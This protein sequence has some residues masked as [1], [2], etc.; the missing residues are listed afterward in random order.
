MIYITI[1]QGA[2]TWHVSEYTHTHDGVLYDGR[3]LNAVKIVSQL[4]EAGTSGA[5]IDLHIKNPDR[6]VSGNLWAAIVEVELP[7]GIVWHGEVKAY[8]HDGE[9]VLYVSVSDSGLP[10]LDLMIPDEVAHVFDVSDLHSSFVDFTVPIALGGTTANPLF[11]KGILISKASFV[12]LLSVGEI[13][14]VIKVYKGTE[15]ITSGFTAYTGTSGQAQYPGF[16]CIVFNSDP[17]NDDGTWPDI[18]ADVVGVKLGTC[19][20]AECRN[21]ARILYYLLTTARTGIG[22][23]GLGVDA[24]KIDTASF[25]QAIADCDTFG[26]H[27]DGVIH[28]KQQARYWVDQITRACRGNY[29]T[30]NGKRY[31]SIGKT[32]S[33]VQTYD[34]SN[35]RLERHGK[36]NSSKRR[37]RVVIDYRYNPI[38]QCF[39][40]NETREDSASISLIKEQKFS[41]QLDLVSEQATAGAIA[42]FELNRSK[43]GE[44]RIYF[45]TLTPAQPGQVI[46]INRPDLGLNNALFCVTSLDTGPDEYLI[47]AQSYSDSIHTISTPGAA[48]SDV[49]GDLPVTSAYP[50]AA[51]SGLDVHSDV[52]ILPDGSAISY[53]YGSYT[54]PAG[55]YLGA[56]VQWG[57]G[58]NPSTWTALG[59]IKG[60]TFRLSPV[61]GGTTYTIKVT[62]INS[63]GSSPSITS[64]ITAAGDTV[65]PGIP[66]I[67]ATSKFTFASLKIS[68][69]TPPDDL[70]GFRIY[71]GTTDNFN[72][73]E[74][75]A[76]VTSRDGIAEYTDHLPN[77]TDGYMYFAKAYDRWKNIGAAS[78]ASALVR[79]AR[80]LAADILRKLTPADALNTDPYFEDTSAWSN[81]LAGAVADPAHF[82]TVS[83]GIAGGTEFK[84]T[85]GERAVFGV[86]LDGLVPYDLT[87]KYV[88]TAFVRANGGTNGLGFAFYDSAKTL[89]GTTSAQDSAISATSTWT[90]FS[91]T[92]AE[93]PSGTRYISPAIICNNSSTA[94]V[95]VEVQK[96]RLREVLTADILIANEAIITSAIQIAEGIINNAHIANLDAEK[97]TS[98]ILDT[99]RLSAAVAAVSQLTA[100]GKNLI[101]DPS[102]LDFQNSFAMSGT[103]T[104]AVVGR[105]TIAG[106]A[107]IPT[108]GVGVLTAASKPTLVMMGK[109]IKL[110]PFAAS[111]GNR[112]WMAQN[113]A[114][115]PN[116]SY[117]FSAH[118]TRDDAV[119]TDVTPPY[120]L[121]IEWRSSA[122]YLSQVA[123][124]ND[125]PGR[126]YVSGTAPE[127]ASYAILYVMLPAH[128]PVSGYGANMVVSAVQFERASVATFWV[129]R[130]QGTITADRIFTGILRSLN[131]TYSSGDF[132]TAGMTLDL[133][134]GLIRSRKFSI[135]SDGNAKFSGDISGAS[136]SFVG[137][138]RTE[139]YVISPASGSTGIGT[140]R[141]EYTGQIKIYISNYA[142]VYDAPSYM[143]YMKIAL[144]GTVAELGCSLNVKNGWQ[145][146]PWKHVLVGDTTNERLKL[147]FYRSD[148]TPNKYY[149]VIGETTTNWGWGAVSIIEATRA[150]ASVSTG[151]VTGTVQQTLAS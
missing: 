2:S 124:T 100:L 108:N 71:R 98:G 46:T 80:I 32:G 96:T 21:P 31:L 75:I 12:Y 53:I 128:T 82:S 144:P 3:L 117:C 107:A 67:I 137:E 126:F 81:D 119:P 133:N 102:F 116:E 111:S 93:V 68:L 130:E 104:E 103:A 69:A 112:L 48:P 51:P 61:I 101:E 39:T 6:W 151:S 106:D 148:E 132:S 65:A 57:I 129:G 59:T 36:G 121:I 45:G 50:P 90:E 56:L 8:D 79:G 143:I 40:A 127:T 97:I 141:G 88:L 9:G 38:T 70:A 73:A 63:A 49:T 118:V 64:T 17:R 134:T 105:W 13:R 136:G 26:F 146:D 139:D 94:G 42:D 55:A 4:S 58:A 23:W 1:T 22:G 115:K 99:A 33:S 35:M 72:D 19:T 66:T 147:R 60:N 92:F 113:V 86:S 149:I 145:N 43:Y 83:D 131:Y 95:V 85:A 142:G 47:D 29:Y 120:D 77:Y 37:N 110:R 74:F 138:V 114:V 41:G 109:G 15:E 84:T 5:G 150:I 34:L 30:Y 14:S 54:L 89:L 62:A 16:A 122:G 28:T 87:R 20:E 76:S 25:T 7:S 91:K 24:S 11:V 135:D 140:I 52:E 27:I 10:E 18:Y 125:A 123:A 44:D 78:A